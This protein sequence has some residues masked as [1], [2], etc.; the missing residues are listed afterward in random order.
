MECISL[1]LARVLPL[2]QQMSCWP[3][4][5]ACQRRELSSLT[6]GEALLHALANHEATG[7]PKDAG[8]DSP[9]GFDLVC[10]ARMTRQSMRTWCI[11]QSQPGDR[12]LLRKLS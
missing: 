7:I 3:S 6:S 4:H 5:E 11:S 8:T 12:H 2:F 10:I 9:A 1:A